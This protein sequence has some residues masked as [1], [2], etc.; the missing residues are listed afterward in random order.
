MSIEY[1]LVDLLDSICN[2]LGTNC[3]EVLETK[4]TG[5]KPKNKE[6]LNR[7]DKITLAKSLFVYW[8]KYK[9]G[10]HNDFLMN[11]LE[12]KKQSSL[13]LWYERGM[14]YSSSLKL[15]YRI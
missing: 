11:L 7:R 6:Q 4:I 13:Y 1:K 14:E 9:Y 5:R 8:A 2:A 10:I 3:K 15:D 12:I